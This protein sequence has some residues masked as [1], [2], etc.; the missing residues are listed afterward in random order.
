MPPL[1]RRPRASARALRLAGTL[2]VA[3]VVLLGAGAVV[4]VREGRAAGLLP[5]RSWG[6]WTATRIEAWSTHVRVNTWGDAAQ[7]EIHFGKAED[8]TLHAYGKTARATGMMQPT[9]FTLT[10]DGKLTARRLS[11]P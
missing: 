3:L 4:A 11:A 10:P 5:E 7:A 1:S 8:L 2:A 9:V 6:P